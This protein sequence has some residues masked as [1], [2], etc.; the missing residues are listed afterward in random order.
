MAAFAEQ[1]GC[2]KEARELLQ[3]AEELHQDGFD[4]IFGAWNFRLWAWKM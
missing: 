1:M 4:R 3:E 2:T